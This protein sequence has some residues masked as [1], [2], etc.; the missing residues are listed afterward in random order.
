M[1]YTTKKNIIGLLYPKAIYGDLRKD[2]TFMSYMD[3]EN[4]RVISCLPPAILTSSRADP[5]KRASKQYYR[6]LKAAGNKC[7]FLYYGQKNKE[8]THAFV[9]LRPY[10]P[11][12]RDALD[13]ICEWFE[14]S[15]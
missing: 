8:L 4:S 13:K 6:A 3:P 7:R 11:E 2:K 15:V 5:L 12:S 9:N 14:A 10:L 1:F